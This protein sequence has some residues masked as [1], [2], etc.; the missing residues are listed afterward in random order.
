M[1]LVVHEMRV[2]AERAGTLWR[3]L[4]AA[5]RFSWPAGAGRPGFRADRHRSELCTGACRPWG[6]SPWGAGRLAY[7]DTGSGAARLRRPRCG[8]TLRRRRRCAAWRRSAG[9]GIGRTRMR[10]AAC[11]L[12]RLAPAEADRGEALQQATTPLL[13]ILGRQSA[14]RAWRAVR[15]APASAVRRCAA[16]AARGEPGAPAA[17]GMKAVGLAARLRRPW[18]RRGSGNSDGFGCIGRI[19]TSS[20]AVMRQHGRGDRGRAA[21]SIAVRAAGLRPAPGAHAATGVAR[22]GSLRSQLDPVRSAAA[23]RRAASGS[24]RRCRA[25]AAAAAGRPRAASMLIDAGRHHRD[26]DDAFEALVEGRADDDVGVLVDLLA[27]AGRGLVDL[28][29]R[30]VACRR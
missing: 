10:A 19:V 18:L 7:S 30:E 5:M 17:G 28:V 15:S 23:G 24:V 27:D 29:Q 20:I 14:R 3:D 25:S 16:C 2:P 12:P 8:R 1:S 4:R 22:G 13:R 21:C 11:I 9:R 26:A 6:S